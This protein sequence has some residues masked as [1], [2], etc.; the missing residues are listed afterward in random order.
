MDSEENYW[1]VVNKSFLLN[2]NYINKP[3]IVCGS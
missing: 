3:N 2:K 1:A